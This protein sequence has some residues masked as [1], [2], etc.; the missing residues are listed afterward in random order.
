MAKKDKRVKGCPNKS[1]DAH[2]KIKYAAVDHFCKACGSELVYVCPKCF[3]ALADLG[4]DHIYCESCQAAKQDKIDA[5]VDGAKK[6]GGVAVAAVVAGFNSE[7][8]KKLR[9]LGADAAKKG[10]DVVKDGIVKKAIKD[11]IIK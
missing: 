9:K 2:K 5:I 6:A 1:C 4:P 7:A 10:F 8:G 11:V 3:R